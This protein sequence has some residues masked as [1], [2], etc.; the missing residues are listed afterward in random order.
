MSTRPQSHRAFF[1]PE[2]L[3]SRITAIDVQRDL[4]G[5]G[6]DSVLLDIDN[7]IRSR[8]DGLVPSD[9]LDWLA[10]AR[11]A[12]VSFCLLSNNWHS[13]VHEFAAELELPI[14]AKA[15]KPLPFSY[16]RAVRALG[17]ARAESV[18][19]GDQLFTDVVGA[20]LLGIQAYMVLPL[21]EADLKHTLALRNLERSFI[22]AM[23]PE[24]VSAAMSAERGRQGV[25]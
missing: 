8:E 12:G 6:L 25:V 21:A 19:V 10:N 7:T 23:E 3:F 15:C 14:V 24:P 5:K 13:D 4:L 17:A 20:H 18:A 2:R 22:Q 16:L 11:D 9:V 1:E